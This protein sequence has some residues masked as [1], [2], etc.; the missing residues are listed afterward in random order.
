MMKFFKSIVY[1]KLLF[2]KE[3]SFGRDDLFKFPKSSILLFVV[4][5]LKSKFEVSNL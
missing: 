3:I 5:K 4:E 2:I 1:F